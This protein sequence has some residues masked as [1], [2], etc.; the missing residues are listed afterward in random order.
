V[1]QQTGMP[2]QQVLSTLSEHLPEFI[3]QMTP[4]GRLPTDDEASRW[5]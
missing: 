1:A 3:N 2:R 4:D 5:V